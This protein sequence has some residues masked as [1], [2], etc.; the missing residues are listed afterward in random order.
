[1]TT[2]VKG[3]TSVT[4]H[5]KC[6]NVDVE[7]VMGYLNHVAMAR[8][9]QVLKPGRGKIDV[10][11]RIHSGKEIALP[12]QT[13]VGEITAANIILALLVQKPTEHGSGKGEATP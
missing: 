9:Y 1:M 12:K 10:C 4:T 11:L 2:V 6:L 5:S 8:S 3:I 7:P 13:I